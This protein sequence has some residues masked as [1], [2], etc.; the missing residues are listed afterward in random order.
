MSD[1]NESPCRPHES[2]AEPSSRIH[3]RIAFF[4]GLNLLPTVAGAVCHYYYRNMLLRAVWLSVP[5]TSAPTHS[6]SHPP[7][8][9]H[10][11]THHPVS[12]GTPTARVRTFIRYRNTAA[13]CELKKTNFDLCAYVKPLLPSYMYASVYCFPVLPSFDPPCPHPTARVHSPQAPAAQQAV[14]NNSKEHQQQATD[15]RTYHKKVN[16]RSLRPIVD[17]VVCISLSS[18]SH[19]CVMHIMYII[20]LCL[21]VYK[22][23]YSSCSLL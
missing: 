5:F 10:Q 2:A 13:S 19:A 22:D 9:I 7:T 1:R 18:I 11:S 21:E 14:N 4:L 15:T 16:V 8:L 3:A 17:P 12:F 6:P 20:S 23:R